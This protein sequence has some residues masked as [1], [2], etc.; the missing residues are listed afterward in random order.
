MVG[1]FKQGLFNPRNPKKYKGNVSNICFRSSWELEFCKFCDNN[2]NVLEWASE[3]IAIP[4]V[5][6]TDNRVHTYYPD[7]WVKYKDKY[8]KIIQEVIEIKPMDQVNGPRKNIRNHKQRLYEQLTYAVNV[9]KWKYATKWCSDRGI[10]F[11]LVTEQQ[12]FSGR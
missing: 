11:R 7:F 4:Y 6:P 12:L 8:G 3:E 2:I 10:K 9:A 1:T 5:K